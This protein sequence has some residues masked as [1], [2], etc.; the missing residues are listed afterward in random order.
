MQKKRRVSRTNKDVPK[1]A[2]V[3]S[4]PFVPIEGV[5]NIGQILKRMRNQR[6]LTIREVAEGSELSAS[7]LSAVEREE[8]DIA[9]GRLARLAAFFEQD[10]GSLLGFKA[11][12]GRP[13]FLSQIDR[14]RVNRGRGIDYESL[15]L[16]GTNL[17]LQVM[18]FE[19]RSGFRD[20]LTH[21][22]ID[23]VMAIEGQV[24][25]VVDR[26]D[27]PLATGQCTVY[28]ASFP[29]KLRNDS[30]RRAVAIGITTAR[31]F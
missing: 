19:P 30:S 25:L 13:T 22:G 4:D 6:N 15:R 5:P 29:H 20:E 24:I 28:S 21:E 17:Q 11:H 18:R 27:Y 16:P 10:I 14:I 9:L 7:F 3:T 31:L 8:S 2:K 26:V 1:D 12:I 23:V